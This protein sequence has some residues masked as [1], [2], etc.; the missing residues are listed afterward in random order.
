LRKRIAAG[1]DSSEILRL[2][3]EESFRLNELVSELVDFSKPHKY[4]AE[5]TDLRRL[6]VR[7]LELVAPDL[8]KHK[9]STSLSFSENSWE[10]IVNKNQVF[11][12]MLNLLVNAI[13]AMSEG[14]EGGELTVSGSMQRPE[15]K[16]G[17]FLAFS[18][19]DTG[20]GINKEDQPR[21]FDRYFTTKET[22]TG[23][24]LAVVERVMS[25]HNGT[26]GVES[27]PGKGSTITLY[28]PNETP[29][30]SLLAGGSANGS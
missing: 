26:V 27:E 30:Q 8:E 17:E 16:E 5:K 23:L 10:V 18:V 24:G 21:L 6:A 19:A 15:F 29:K 14:P 11:E 1:E 28:F 13:D 12:A 2:I 25:A 20:C 9:I 3:E 22:G 7:A 4:E